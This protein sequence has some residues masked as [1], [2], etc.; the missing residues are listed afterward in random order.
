[1]V[2]SDLRR[3]RLHKLFQ[4]PNRFGLTDQF[5]HPQEFLNGAVQPTEVKNLYAITSGS[6][7]P[8]PSELISSKRMNEIIQTLQSQYELVFL[9]APPS[10]VVTD[11]NVM[12]NRAD[13]VLL[14]VRPSITKRAAIKHTI[15]AL[16]QVNAKI[17][18]I[19]LNG[20][21]VKK[22][23]YSYY[24]GYYHKYGRGYSYD[25]DPGSGGT[26][27]VK[28]PKGKSRENSLLPELENSSDQPDKNK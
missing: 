20:V 4:L 23:R 11:A 15:E 7:P 18:G 27:K 26:K 21:N 19:V 1:M 17:V 3:P 2:D 6:L 9:D 8:N 13:G 10:L 14:V 24:R 5:I 16:G 12:A 28:S 25:S 22:S